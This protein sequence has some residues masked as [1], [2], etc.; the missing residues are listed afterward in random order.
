MINFMINLKMML[1]E[2]EVLLENLH[3][4]KGKQ[5]SEFEKLAKS[6]EEKVSTAMKAISC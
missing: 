5:E 2:D 4:N 1:L 6:E 3:E